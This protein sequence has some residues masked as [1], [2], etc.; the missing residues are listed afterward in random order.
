MIAVQADLSLLPMHLACTSAGANHTFDHRT[1][2]LP[3]YVLSKAHLWRQGSAARG[4][5]P[6]DLVAQFLTTAASQ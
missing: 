1:F 4:Q 6:G 5:D 2:T 3:V